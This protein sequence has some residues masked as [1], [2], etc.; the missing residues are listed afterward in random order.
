MDYLDRQVFQTP[1]WMLDQDILYRIQD[2]GAPDRIQQLQA[3]ALNRLLNVAR[4]KRL[5]EDEAFRGGTAYGL[6]EMLSDLRESVWSELWG[7]WEIDPFR[8]NLQRAYLA[9]VAALMIDEEAALTDIVPFLRGELEAI[10]QRIQ[11]GMVLRAAPGAT[12][13]HL[14]DVV[15]RIDEILEPGG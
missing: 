14:E 9:R 12:R 2:S 3:G 11:T 1:G 6:Q 13:L 7:G 5:I 4:M 15:I 8:R 10:K